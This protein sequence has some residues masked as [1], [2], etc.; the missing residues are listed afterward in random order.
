MQ[1]QFLGTSA[2]EGWPGMFCNCDQCETARL[3]G[4]K[5]IRT[6]SQAVLYAD[7]VGSGGIDDILLID[8]PPDTY[9]HVVQHGLRLD[10]VGHLIV[11]HSHDDHFDPKEFFY[12]CGKFTNPALTSPL[13]IYGNEK[14]QEKFNS[15]LSHLDQEEWPLGIKLHVAENFVPFTAGSYTVTPMP[16]LHDPQERCLIYMIESGGPGQSSVKRMIYG[17]D[18]GI[19]PEEVFEFIAGKSFDLITLDCTHCSNSEGTNHMGLPDAAELK[20]RLDIMG[21]LKPNTKI[22]LQHF[23]HYNGTYYDAMVELAAPHAMDVAYDGGV[24]EI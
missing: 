13:H 23:S 15:A 1:L 24:W 11:T 3:L 19:F 8:F 6:R 20:R 12:R 21:C 5:N 14:V 22:V 17:T 16:A 10:R 4:R 7:S 2:A 9:T 18:T